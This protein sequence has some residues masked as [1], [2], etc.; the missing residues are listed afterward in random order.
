MLW[1]Y[2]SKLLAGQQA[3]LYDEVACRLAVVTLGDKSNGLSGLRDKGLKNVNMRLL[4][5]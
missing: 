3:I 2:W 5:A 1:I 4:I